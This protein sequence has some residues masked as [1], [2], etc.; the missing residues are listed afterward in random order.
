MVS[1]KYNYRLKQVDFNGNFEY[2]NLNSEI[3][4][5]TPGKFDLSQNYPNPFN[6]STNISFDLASDGFVSVKIFDYLGREVSSL[7]ND[8]RTAGYYS[9]DF[10]AANMSSGVCFYKLESNGFSKVMKMSLIK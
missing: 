3:E 4:I 9:V 1:G 6:P 2:H 8:F 5:G 7:V 10:N